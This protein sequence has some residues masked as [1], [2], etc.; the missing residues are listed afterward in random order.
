MFDSFLKDKLKFGIR[1]GL[2]RIEALLDRLGNPHRGPRILHIAGTN[3]KGSVAAMLESI[4][5]AAGFRVGRYTSPHLVRYTERFLVD[6][7]EVSASRFDAVLSEV[8]KTAREIEG[9]RDDPFTEFELL[10][11]AAFLLF[12]REML[13]VWVIETGMG[14]RWDATNV[15]LP[16][17]SIITNVAL[18]HAEVLG[19]TVEA[20]A[21]EKA[22]ILKPGVPILT[23]ATGSALALIEKR[24][25]E[26]GCPMLR[27]EGAE[28]VA[29]DG[30]DQVFSYGGK[31]YALSLLGTYQWQNAPL[32]IEAA[33]LLRIPER[34]IQEGLST[35]RWPGRFE[36]WQDEEGRNWL[37]DGAH[38]P[39]GMQELLF[40]LEVFFPGEVFALFGALKDKEWPGMLDALA[41][42][43][44]VLYVTPDSMRALTPEALWKQRP[45]FPACRTVLEGLERAKREAGKRLIVVCGSLYLVGAAR[46]ALGL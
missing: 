40:S 36:V 44:E 46:D 2:E 23:G 16:E 6:G 33:R 19:D 38:N 5:R 20:I 10:T 22:G 21:A 30:G 11:A 28:F 18:D 39:A 1:P 15:V 26:L 3:G 13:N 37:F 14:G 32:A 24:A 17:L 29:A 7:K 25:S 42:K 31:D 45:G 43:A 35:V 8:E 9:E 4:L 27:P 12:A 41:Q 34:T